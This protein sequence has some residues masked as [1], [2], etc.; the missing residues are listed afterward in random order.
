MEYSLLLP[1]LILA[2]LGMVLIAVDLATNEKRTVAA[3]G[4]VGTIAALW[5]TT[6]LFGQKADIWN[7]TIR[8]DDFAAFFK[9]VFLAILGLIFL[10]S[11]E[12][13]EKR[14]VKVGEFY[15]LTTF[16]TLGAMVMASSLNLIT[17]YLSLE[18]LTLSSYAL[19][20][21]LKNDGRSSEASLKFF[22]VGALNSGIILYGLSLL[23]GLSGSVFLPEVGAA[24]ANSANPS[25]VTAATVLVLAGFG[26]KAAAVPFHMWAPDTYDGAPTPVSAFLITASEAAAFAALVR[27]LTVGLA[28]MTDQWQI[29]VAALAAV[30]MTYG[31]ITAI[32]QTRTKRML[33]YSAIAQAGYL[34]VGV[35]VASQA[36]VSAMLF[37]VLV[38]ALMT[39]GAFAVVIM[40]SNHVPSEQ[41]ED[42][43]GL[44]RRTPAL[45]LAMGILLLSLIGIPPTAG[46]LGKFTLVRAAIDGGFL[47]LALLMMIN[48]AISIPYYFRI[49][50]NM[51]LEG[52]EQS[53]PLPTRLGVK[54]AVGISVAGV[55]LLGVFPES[56]LNFLANAQLLP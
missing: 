45:A 19:T 16:A 38:Y 17:I 20:G 29:L 15:I 37:Y 18:L 26:F 53:A 10:F 13:L 23:F 28:P 30:T 35:A 1:E 12:Y 8:V 41:I 56:V 54:V 33:A 6:T 43:K 51:Y 47:W 5:A 40:L 2:L 36:S 27:I 11:G 7:G 48:S 52:S 4:L 44:A 32:R 49:I 55:F 50:R 9:V 3:V 39:L 22:L 42:F 46:F 21:M 34:L 31:N 14:N 24:V 25:L